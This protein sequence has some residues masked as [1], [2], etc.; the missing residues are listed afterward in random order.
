MVN[1]QSLLK[2]KQLVLASCWM[3]PTALFGRQIIQGD[4]SEQVNIIRSSN[5]YNSNSKTFDSTVTLTCRVGSIREPITYVIT[6][7]N[8]DSVSLVNA[9]GK[10]SSGKPYIEVPIAGGMLKNGQRVSFVAKFSNPKRDW[11]RFTDQVLGVLSDIGK[12]VAFSWSPPKETLT[13]DQRKQMEK[14][15]EE[16]KKDR[17]ESS[18]SKMGETWLLEAIL[19]PEPMPRDRLSSMEECADWILNCHKPGE[20]ELD[21]C[22]RSAPKCKTGTPWNEESPCCPGA[23]YERYRSARLA[24]GDEEFTSTFM[25]IYLLEGKD[26]CFPPDDGT[27]SPSGAR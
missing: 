12:E 13:P 25:R 24:S 19:D 14:A 16:K 23:C 18:N 1:R 10:T 26:N 8:N 21:D 3:V 2:V 6:N 11:F 7:I 20:R 4:V 9:T 17:K 27:P 5:V 15:L 22:A